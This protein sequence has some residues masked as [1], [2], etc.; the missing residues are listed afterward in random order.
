MNFTSY[1]KGEGYYEFI[2][3]GVEYLVPETDVILVDDESGLLTI[4]LLATR[5]VVGTVP[6][7]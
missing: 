2:G 7:Q 6:K 4:K 5:K 1:V 3:D